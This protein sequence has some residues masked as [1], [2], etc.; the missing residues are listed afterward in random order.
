[1][2]VRD[3]RIGNQMVATGKIA[4]IYH[5]SS[6]GITITLDTGYDV[7]LEATE[8]VECLKKVSTK[9]E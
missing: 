1:M 6:G 7:I 8:L 5:W 2:E 4:S 9:T 3:N